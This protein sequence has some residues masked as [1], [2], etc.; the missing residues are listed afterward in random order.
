MKKQLLF[1]CSIL[2][3]FSCS[4]D[5]DPGTTIIREELD[6]TLTSG[7]WVVDLFIEDNEDETSDYENLRFSFLASGQVEVS[8]GGSLIETGSWRTRIDDGFIVLDLNLSD[9]DA[10]DDL[11]DDWYLIGFNANRIELEEDD[12]D[13]DDFLILRKI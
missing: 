3:L 11:S 5:S 4:E 10:L 1:F 13:A 7:V 6:S 9:D 2:L 8:E 12:D